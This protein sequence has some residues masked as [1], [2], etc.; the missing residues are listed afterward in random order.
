MRWLDVDF[1]AETSDCQLGNAFTRFMNIRIE[2]RIPF[3]IDHHAK[4]MV[5]C[6]LAFSK[7]YL[8]ATF[9]F[10]MRFRIAGVEQ[11]F[12]DLGYRSTP[13]LLRHQDVID[14]HE[15]SGLRCNR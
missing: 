5:G 1:D 11:N 6:A 7:N 10:H 4:T 3:R 14:V 12:H 9:F 8:V 2:M 13:E 15:R